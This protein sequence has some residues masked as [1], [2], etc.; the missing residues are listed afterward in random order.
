RSLAWHVRPCLLS[1]RRLS[2]RLFSLGL[3]LKQ[4]P[5]TDPYALS[6]HDALPI[7]PCSGRE[8]D[9]RVSMTSISTRNASPGRTGFDQISSSRRSEEHTSE[10]QSPYDLV[11]RL[12]LEKKKF[13]ASTDFTSPTTKSFPNSPNPQP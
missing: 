3:S 1:C 4:P 8:R 12:L 7:S 5:P 9:G 11:C 13:G 6:L 10:L 2:C